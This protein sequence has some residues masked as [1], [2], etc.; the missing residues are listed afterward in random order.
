MNQSQ[1]KSNFSPACELVKI[2]GSRDKKYY[3]YAILLLPYHSAPTPPTSK[4]ELTT[5]DPCS[6][7]SN[8]VVV[9]MR[10]GGG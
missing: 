2:V 8:V 3:T 1:K 5:E 10:G 9:S 4:H 6:D 7:F